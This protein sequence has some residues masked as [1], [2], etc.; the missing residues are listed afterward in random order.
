MLYAVVNSEALAAVDSSGLGRVIWADFILEERGGE[1]TCGGGGHVFGKLLP[2]R[3]RVQT[4]GLRQR[5]QVSITTGSSLV[6]MEDNLQLVRGSKQ[7]QTDKKMECLASS[8]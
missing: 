8:V 6:N 2:Q 5:D 7:Q 3:E 1:V 4:Q